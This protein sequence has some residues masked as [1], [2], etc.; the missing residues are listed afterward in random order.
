MPIQ[1]LMPALSP[2]MEKGNL[3]KWL[4]KEGEAIKSGDVIAEIETDKATME[5]EAT[6]EGTLG[7]ILVAEGTNDVAVN[8]PIA[9]ILSDGESAADLGKAPAAAAAKAPEPSVQVKQEVEE[10]RSPVGEGKPQIS[11]P[12]VVAAPAAPV[13]PDPEVPPG[14]EMVKMTVRE[15]LRDA[16]AEEMRRDPDV[17][18]MGEEVAEY[19]G[20]YKI[21]QGLLQEFGARRVIDT[22]ITEHGF[23]GVGVGAAMAG[24]KPIVEFMTFNF[25]MQAIDQIINSAAKTLY[26]SGGQMGCSIVFRGPNGAAARVAAQHS[27]DYSAWYSQIPGLKVVSPYSAADAKGLLKAAIRDPNP[28]IFLENEILYGH[29]GDVPKLDDY[30]V[31]IGKARIVRPGK[32][33]TLISW[34]N[35][36]TYALGAADELAK[37]GIEAEVIDLRTL[38]PMDTETIINSVKKTGRAVAVEEGWQQS[39]VGAEIAARIME[40][41]FDYLDAPVARVSGKDVPM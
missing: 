11:A 26:M 25:A 20:A 8:T 4:K 41:A 5:V 9:T 1:V 12:P 6:D 17:F 32:D 23:A 30:V 27:Q 10:S 34:S 24:L 7:K 29:T 14:T 21:T 2:T 15:A 3:S 13:E 40:Q 31:P 18:V 33:V 35:G 36:M 16:M 28:V 39:G 22:P 37:E 19:Q 38:R